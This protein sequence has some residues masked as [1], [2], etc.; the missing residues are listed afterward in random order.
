MLIMASLSTRL[1]EVVRRAS[2]VC[3]ERPVPVFGVCWDH[4]CVLEET[5]RP[6]KGSTQAMERSR[7][8]KTR[9]D[10][11]GRRE[12]CST[13][14]LDITLMILNGKGKVWGVEN[15]D[16]WT[17]IYLGKEGPDFKIPQIIAVILHASRMPRFALLQP[18]IVM[19]YDETGAVTTPLKLLNTSQLL[20]K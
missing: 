17:G 9:Q 13:K 8:V 1:E 5:G 19:W 11:K 15:S 3:E 6:S 20:V 12:L 14:D 2:S 4:N 7:F 10:V 16:R 18:Q